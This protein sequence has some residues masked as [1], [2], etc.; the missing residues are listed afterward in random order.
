M[1]GIFKKNSPRAL[2]IK[3]MKSSTQIMAVDSAQTMEVTNT[4]NVI[5]QRRHTTK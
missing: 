4:N 2:L 1:E 3:S 5:S